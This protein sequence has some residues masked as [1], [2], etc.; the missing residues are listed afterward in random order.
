MII[1]K[2]Q[3]NDRLPSTPNAHSGLT[4]EAQAVTGRSRNKEWL[5]HAHFTC[6]T[7]PSQ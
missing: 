4:P 2:L 3:Q 1:F 7:T 5:F 6:A